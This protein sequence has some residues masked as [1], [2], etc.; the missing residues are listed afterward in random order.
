MVKRKDKLEAYKIRIDTF[1]WFSAESFKPFMSNTF[2]QAPT[3]RPCFFVAKG[4]N[5]SKNQE[6]GKVTS[7]NDD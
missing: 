7:Y 2:R 4:Y 5:K 1:I 6:I 3:Y